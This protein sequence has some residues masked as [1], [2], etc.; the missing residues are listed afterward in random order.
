MNH[1]SP[2]RTGLAGLIA[3]LGFSLSLPAAAQMKDVYEVRDVVVDVTAETAAKAR[4]QALAEGQAEAFRRL[5]KRLTLRSENERLPDLDAEEITT[6]VKDFSVASEKVSAVRYLAHL[7]Y[8]FKREE[9]RSLLND[10]DLRFAETVSKPVLVLAVYQDVGALML[11]DDPNPWR[12]AWGARPDTQS[13]VPTL[14]PVGDLSD[15][16]AIG[17]EQAMEGDLQRLNAIAKNYG[18]SDTLVVFG[19]MRVDAAKARRV[20]EV[21]FTR[22]GTQLQEQT[23]V[24]N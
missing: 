6:Y 2:R 23:E 9:I 15:I 10:F 18:A 12:E 8:R 22:Y 21:Y 7:N 1:L 4:E 3:G 19:V 16:A 5:L 24:M 11:W 13:L 14:L 20:L 17:A